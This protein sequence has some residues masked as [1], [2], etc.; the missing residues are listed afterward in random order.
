MKEK[1]GKKIIFILM[2]LTNLVF[3]ENYPNLLPSKV[4]DALDLIV[5]S[6]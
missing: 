4:R 3:F 2:T 5:R 6:F 1:I